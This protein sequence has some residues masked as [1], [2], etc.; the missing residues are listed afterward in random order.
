MQANVDFSDRG[1][2]NT[3]RRLRYLVCGAL[4]GLPLVIAGVSALIGH[5]LQYSLSD[6]YFVAIDGGLPRTLFLVFLS[7]L[8]GTLVAY[9]GLDDRDNLIHN[10]AGICAFGVALF[11]MACD[12]TEHQ[13]CVPGLLPSLHLPSAGLLYLAAIASVWYGGGPRLKAALAQLPTSK[14]WA[15]RRHS[16]QVLSATLMTIG[17]AAFFSHILLPAL[18]PEF[19]WIFWIEY[20]GFLGFGVYWLRLLLLINSANI[21]GRKAASNRLVRPH[22]Q[23]SPQSTTVTYKG[24]ITI[25][26][27]Q[28]IDIP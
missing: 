24:Q 15:S 19:S 10:I 12:T 2:A 3:Y 22:L 21:E 20:A 26:D 8:G 9:R 5:P 23:Q 7:F 28:W 11:P 1:V 13:H 14:A 27:Q 4:I 17:I 25:A 18:L 6:Y 16:I